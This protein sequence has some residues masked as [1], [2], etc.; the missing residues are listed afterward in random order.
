[1]TLHS[2]PSAGSCPSSVLVVDD[3][4]AN[5]AVLCRRL[6]RFGY[7][8]A[9][10]DSGFAALEHVA[11]T[12]P[13]IILLDFMM[14]RMNGIEVLKVLRGNPATR[15]IPVIMVTARAESEATIEALG[16]GADDYVSKPIDFDVLRA[17]VEAHLS[18]RTGA[19]DLRR[20]NAALD[21]RVTLRSM[22]LAD[23]EGE[24]KGEIERRKDLERKLA[25]LQANPRAAAVHDPQ[26]LDELLE[27]I[28]SRVETVFGSVTDGRA[29]NLAQMA[30]LRILVDQACKA[31]RVMP[32]A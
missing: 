2:N 5:R 32:V 12:L 8:V 9:S 6:E 30:E 17:R 13:D 18:K 26:R 4:E 19:C 29:A 31:A 3:M 10:V 16:A 7:A 11:T 23:L 22:A 15:D 1:M 21:E 27:K 24:L 28:R 14:P 25:S 20:A